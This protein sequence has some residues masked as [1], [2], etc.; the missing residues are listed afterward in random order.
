MPTIGTL[1]HGK[2]LDSVKLM[3][4]SQE[5]RQQD[6]VTDAV[7][8]MATQENKAILKATEMLLPEFAKALDTDICIAVNA[9]TEARCEE[10]MDMVKTWID[11]G[12]PGSDTQDKA[13]FMPRSIDSA[14]KMMPNAN[15]ALISVAGKYAGAETKKALD[16][17]LNVMLFSDNVSI[18]T[19]KEL[20]EYAI[21][22]DLLMMGPDCGTAIINGVP[23]AFANAVRKGKIGIVSASGTGLQE[24]S[25]VINNCGEGISQAF[26]TGGRDG[27]K[28]IG[29]LMLLKCLE[30]LLFDL[31]TEVIVLISKVPDKEVIAKMWALIKLTEKPV[32][33]NFLRPFELPKDSNVYSGNTLAETA[34]IACRILTDKNDK[35]LALKRRESDSIFQNRTLVELPTKESRKYLRG[36]FSGGTLCYEAQNLYHQKFEDYAYSNAPLESENKLT[37]VWKS[38]E[39]TIIDMGADEFTVGRPHPM[40]DYSLRLKKIEEESKDEETAIILL[41][42]VL[43]FGAHLSPHL[44]LAPILKKV[45]ADTCIIVICAV[46]GTD[47]D[48]Q[49]RQEVIRYLSNTGAIVTTT[50]AEAC[51]LAVRLLQS[52]RS[53]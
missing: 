3:L 51:M 6:G 24:V 13:D 2:Y 45:K 38:K 25:C 36:L 50:N 11:K 48:P 21:S 9:E 34:Q 42:V 52:I 17:G 22:K 33:V 16:L 19:E 31:A 8:I 37:D 12:L 10:V 35:N 7:A 4:I 26:G 44:E 15:L 29:G 40:I 39:D 49:N 1:V 23:L 28:E 30:Y 18:Q 5:M 27:K 47:A 46:I 41:D 32:V 20:K 43:G 53:S 14:V